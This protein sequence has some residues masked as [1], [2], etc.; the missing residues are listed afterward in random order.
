MTARRQGEAASALLA[1]I[2]DASVDAIYSETV[3]GTIL[4]WN[5]GAER[6]FGYRADEAI[7]QSIRMIIPEERRKEIDRILGALANGQRIDPFDSERLRKDG[8]LVPVSIAV[9]LT[10]DAAQA[11]VGH[12]LSPATSPSAEWPPTR[13]PIATGSRT[14]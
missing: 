4:S 12:R 6:L 13:S 1:G 5:K 10:R 8:T 9:S 3:T 7:G 14:R 2:V 11:V